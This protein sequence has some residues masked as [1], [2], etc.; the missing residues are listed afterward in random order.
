[1]S[2]PVPWSTGPAAGCATDRDPSRATPSLVAERYWELTVEILPGDPAAVWPHGQGTEGQRDQPAPFTL[3]PG[4]VRRPLPGGVRSAVGDAR[5]AL[6]PPDHGPPDH[7]PGDG[8]GTDSATGIGSR[9]LSE[10]L[11]YGYGLVRH[12]LGPDVRWPHHRAVA[13]ARCFYPVELYLWTPGTD[14]LPTGLYH[15]DPAH[16][17]LAEV[18][19]GLTAAELSAAA[20][21]AVDG[22]DAVLLL[23][24]HWWRTAFHYR[25]YAY[26]LC[27]QEVG[28]TAGSLLQT[29]AVLGLRAEVRY[30]IAADR[31][32]TALRLAPDEETPMAAVVLGGRPGPALVPPVAEPLPELGPRT[33]SGSAPGA[34]PR[35]DRTL[36]ARLVEMDRAAVAADLRAPA[37]LP[38]PVPAP[39]TAPRQEATVPLPADDT[40]WPDLVDVLAR[41]TSGPYAFSPTGAPVSAEVVGRLLAH[42]LAP[43]RSDLRPGLAR[44]DLDCYVLANRVAGL[45]TGAFR[46]LPREHALSR[47]HH[48]PVGPALRGPLATGQQ[49]NFASSALLCYLVGD[50]SAML[51]QHGENGLR[52]LSHEAGLVAHRLSTA[53]AAAGLAVR[54]VNAFDPDAIRSF[55]RLDGPRRDPVFQI[56]VAPCPPGRTY[57]MRVSF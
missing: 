9:E 56:A 20:G 32:R 45:P 11:R 57:R 49:V 37:P 2:D 7:G 35:L 12:D 26:R 5:T 55:L 3:R 36:C 54:I 19:P 41:R 21:I 51:R 13:S 52:L 50:L 27:T 38:A 53:G 16:H 39:A 42:L 15:Y 17:V 1:M 33:G 30:R 44:P 48:Q 43:Y 8:A 47:I 25:D 24:A 14:G 18:R 22:A 31:L 28:I 29:A 46:L 40:P 4:A 34:A 23:T 6:A 10:L